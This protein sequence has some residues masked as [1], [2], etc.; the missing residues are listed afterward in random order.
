MKMSYSNYPGFYHSE[1]RAIEFLP[2]DYAQLSA[3]VRAARLRR[4]RLR[5]IGRAHS[6][7]MGN[8]P[9]KDELVVRLDNLNQFCYLRDDVIRVQA[10][11]EIKSLQEL[12]WLSGVE[13]PVINGGNGSPSIGGFICAGGIGK[14]EEELDRGRSSRYGGFWENVE[15]LTVMKGNG[16]IQRLARSDEAFLWYF[17][18][19]G[20]FGI[21]LE[22]DLNTIRLE[23][24]GSEV[25]RKGIRSNLG[26]MQ[27]VPHYSS[28]KN[29]PKTFWV[30]VLC[31]DKGLSQAW[32]ILKQW[33]DQN[34][35][36]IAVVDEARWSGPNFKGRPLGYS[37]DI[38]CISHNPPM[39]WNEDSSF[40]VIG[41]AFT[42]PSIEVRAPR[43]IKQMFSKVYKQLLDNDLRLYISVENVN[44]DILAKD[45][46]SPEV[47]DQAKRLRADN[48][49]TSFLNCGWLD[50]EG[51]ME[52]ITSLL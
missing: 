52:G 3:L 33:V 21:I 49:C 34:K 45:Y 10:G 15:S 22:A 19:Q 16:V 9:R 29:L 17:G 6:L 2:S 18:G 36:S 11:A 25:L 37:Y 46:Y 48:H 47:I 42:I 7:H 32:K 12:L 20:Q 40:Q 4:Q 50:E 41:V 28:V 14:T 26:T 39:L 51:N 27:R 35:D 13:L 44:G 43:E 31:R 23:N 30:S 5:V 38:R 1:P 24:E 8:L